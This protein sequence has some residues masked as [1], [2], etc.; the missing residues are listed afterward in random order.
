[1][2]VFCCKI[3]FLGWLEELILD[4]RF[5]KLDKIVGCRYRVF[6]ILVCVSVFLAGVGCL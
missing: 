1:M 2:L 5:L 6:V 4:T 3:K